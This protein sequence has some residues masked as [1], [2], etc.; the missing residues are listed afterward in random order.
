MSWALID[1]VPNPWGEVPITGG[2]QSVTPLVEAYM[3]RVA[4]VATRRDC[5]SRRSHYVPQSYLR[6]W[7]PDRKQVRVLDTRNGIDRLRGL[8]DTCVREN[9][10]RV[11]DAT[12]IQHNQVEAMLAVIDDEMA[13]LLRV[14]RGWR[15][16][17]DFTFAD[18]MSLAVVVAFQMNRTPQARR[19]IT[20]IDDWTVRRAGQPPSD[21][22]NDYF[23]DL[24][25][26]TAYRTADELSSRQLELWDDPRGRF[27]TCDQPVLLSR[28]SPGTPPSTTSS[29]YIWWP[30][31][32]HRLLVF[33]L[34][35]QGHKIV[36]RVANRTDID[37]VRTVFIRGAESAIIALAE[38]RGLPSGKRLLRR[39]QLQVD[40]VPQD[41]KARKCRIGFGWGYSSGTLDHACMTLCAMGKTRDSPLL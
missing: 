16:E 24:L 4:E 17:D 22:T 25:F 29:R 14:L 9:F 26:S 19:L 32:S 27:I 40:C 18:F 20:T 34:V 28:D 35:S 23:V 6:A 8:R 15:P 31:S 36:H 41:V 39:P 1:S 7:S 37:E 33:N 21:L 12:N 30:L 13:R 38:D 2:G 10:Y 11:T 3:A 5:V